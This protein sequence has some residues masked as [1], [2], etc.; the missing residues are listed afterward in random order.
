MRAIIGFLLTVAF[1]ASSCSPSKKSSNSNANSSAN[2]SVDNPANDGSGYE[3]AIVIKEKTEKK[4]IDAE[5]QWLRKHYPGYTLISQSL[6]FKNNKNYDIL[7]IKTNDGEK[8][9]VYFDISNFFG[10]W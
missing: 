2:V 9:D 1:V 8:K 10:K 4:G 5:Y 6:N 3:K 7:S